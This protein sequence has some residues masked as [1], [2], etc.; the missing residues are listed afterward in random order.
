MYED[1]KP[2]PEWFL[3]ISVSLREGSGFG[4]SGMHFMESRH[5]EISSFDNAAE[6]LKLVHRLADELGLG[7]V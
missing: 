1:V 3:D 6:T 2:K 4:G 7:K 5:I